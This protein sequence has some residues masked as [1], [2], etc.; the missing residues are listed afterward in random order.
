MW[1]G[2]AADLHYTGFLVEDSRRGQAISSRRRRD[3]NEVSIT[4][5]PS[6]VN[7]DLTGHSALVTGA[8]SGIGRACAE[9]LSRAGAAVTVLDLDGDAAREV[10]EGI[11]GEALQADLSDYGVLDGL[12]VQSDIIVNNA[13]LQHVAAVE[14]FAPERFSMIIRIMLEAP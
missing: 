2:Q 4:P 8:A 6:S 13:G 11:G 3:M 14:E 12:E 7:V 9:R 5:G 10:A 1:A